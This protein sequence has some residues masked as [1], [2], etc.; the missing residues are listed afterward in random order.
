M[1]KVVLFNKPYGVHSQFRKD[2]DNMQTLADF[3]ADK[4]LRVAGRLDKDSEGLLILTD[5]GGLNHTITTPPTG[6]EYQGI[7][8]RKVYLVQ[9]E[10]LPNDEQVQALQN[11]VLLK[12]GKT[13]PA[14]VKLL[15]DGDLPIA[16]WERNPPIRERKSV[17]T[18]WLEIGI[19]EGKNRQVRRMVA[20]VGLPCLRLIRYQVSEWTLGD[21]AM[22][23]S[24]T[25][26]L[27]DDQLRALGV[28]PLDEQNQSTVYNPR[29][30]ADKS[31][32]TK[33]EKSKL[34]GHSKPTK[35]SSKVIKYRPKS[36]R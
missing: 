32:Q 23:E 5:H 24:R 12:D 16:L 15:A 14:T 13:K 6:R 18:A 20:S 21:L 31:K 22:G 33:S 11:G 7:A 3:F 10:H 36:A 30:Q 25:L 28:S 2:D 4:S 17:P 26:M 29:L 19:V 9:V 8:K 1:A 27:D 34:T 35:P